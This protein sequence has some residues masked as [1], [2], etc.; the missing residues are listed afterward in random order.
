[1][2]HVYRCI[3]GTFTKLITDF[4]RHYSFFAGKHGAKMF[5][6]KCKILSCTYEDDKDNYDGEIFL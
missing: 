5:Y 6:G 1:M 4:E 3:R 2:F